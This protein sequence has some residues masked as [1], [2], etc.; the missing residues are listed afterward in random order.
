MLA[1][2]RFVVDPLATVPTSAARRSDSTQ[3]RHR[4]RPRATPP[5]KDVVGIPAA[6]AE[7]RC[8]RPETGDDSDRYRI[9]AP[10]PN[11]PPTL[12]ISCEAP[13]C[14]GFV[15]CIRLLGAP[16]PTFVPNPPGRSNGA[17]MFVSGHGPPHTSAATGEVL[18]DWP[19]A[20]RQGRRG[21]R[22]R[23]LPRRTLA[24]FPC[25]GSSDLAHPGEEGA[26]EHL[27]DEQGILGQEG[28]T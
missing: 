12:R 28:I 18:P 7:N 3:E 17:T 15:S 14:S 20:P 2:H 9:P 11:G 26:R 21:G 13:I 4:A 10:L 22:S 24:R 1:R 8:R 27:E 25:R 5:A 23:Q 19:D 6:Q 16:R